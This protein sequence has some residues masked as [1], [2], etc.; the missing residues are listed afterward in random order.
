MKSVFDKTIRDEL[1]FRITTLHE[2]STGQWGE[3]NVYQMLAHCIKWSEMIFGKRKYKR[4]FI[5]LL[6]GRLLLKN[7]TKN[8]QQMAKNTP[9]IPDLLTDNTTDDIELL[10]EQLIKQVIRFEAFSNPDFTHPFFGK[11]TVEQ[12]GIHA[13]K[14]LDHHLRQFNC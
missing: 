1:I 9:T 13:F 2:K 14:H 8:N 5:G 10:K 11:M 4:V 3:M 12:I 7:A 6:L